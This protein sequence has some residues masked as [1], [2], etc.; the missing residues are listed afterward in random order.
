MIV[1]IEKENWNQTK[2]ALHLSAPV[3]NLHYSE[4]VPDG[5]VATTSPTDM[6]YTV[7]DLRGHGVELVKVLL[8][9]NEVFLISA[10]CQISTC[11]H[12]TSILS[13]VCTFSN[14]LIPS[15]HSTLFFRLPY[16]I[17]CV[18]PIPWACTPNKRFKAFLHMY[19]KMRW[20]PRSIRFSHEISPHILC[21][22][23]WK[24][25]SIQY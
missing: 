3:K 22:H 8:E 9:K 19:S 4:N 1:W 23:Y 7:H 14:T 24:H 21:N 11:H 5:F 20:L 15:T 6:T 12:V 17:R 10:K 16:S 18:L 13:S 2:I 25:S